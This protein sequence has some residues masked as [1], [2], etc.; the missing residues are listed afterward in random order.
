[1]LAGR[2]SSHTSPRIGLPLLADHPA[3][4]S[5][6]IRLLR[7]RKA[8]LQMQPLLAEIART[9]GQSGETDGIAYFLSTPD[10]ARKRPCVLLFSQSASAAPSAAVL[11]FEYLAGPIGTR[12]FA[13]ADGSGRRDVLAPPE[14]RAHTAAFA[15]RT[16]IARG[17]QIV[18]LAFNE[19]HLDHEPEASGP[20]VIARNRFAGLAEQPVVAGFRS[21]DGPCPAAEWTL[22]EREIPA[23]LPLLP[24]F[25]ATLARIGQRTRSNLRYYRRRAELE[26]GCTYEANPAITLQQFLVFNRTCS[27]AVPEE[28]AAFRFYALARLPHAS[29]RGIRD[30][31]GRWLALV[32]IRRQNQFVDIDWQMNR[33]ELPAQS[34]ATVLRSYLIEHEISLGSTRLYIEGGTP[35]PII[36]SFVKQRIGEL[37][38]KR[39]STCVHLLERFASS[40]FPAKNY[41]G[42]TLTN[43]ELHWRS[44]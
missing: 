23:F 29:L 7:G 26:L 28:L 18:H 5:T 39:N 8:I 2:S 12:V 25:N 9:S 43:P 3:V 17:A 27:Y 14:L 31:D 38:V 35:Q 32:G 4:A 42:R 20:H 24:T 15:A 6:Q 11:L 36:H 40:V 34:L 37:T 10:A 41:I 1:M 16:L 19:G 13:T 44:S 30:R 33:A 21:A 22:L